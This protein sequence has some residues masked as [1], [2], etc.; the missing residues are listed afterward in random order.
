VSRAAGT[1]SDDSSPMWLSHHDA[2]AYDRCTLIGRH[3]VCRRCLVLYPIAFAALI[4]AGAGFRWPSSLDGALLIVLPL[5]AVGEFVLEHLGSTRYHPVRQAVVTVPLAA[6]LGV[7]FDRY[8]DRHADPLFWG[9]VVVY[10]G[11]CVAAVV[12]G[13]RRPPDTGDDPG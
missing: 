2:A 12:L 11:G 5:P 13:G 8:L 1:G 10:G 7:G 4:L 9:M 3:R 6:A